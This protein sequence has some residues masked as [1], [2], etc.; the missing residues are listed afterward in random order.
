MREA[1]PLP[2]AEGVASVDRPEA[3]A[4]AKRRN[5]VASPGA[6][7]GAASSCLPLLPPLSSISNQLLRS[8]Y[9]RSGRSPARC[10]APR[11][12]PPPIATITASARAA[13][14]PPEE[15]SSI[16]CGGG[17]PNAPRSNPPP[18][19]SGAATGQSELGATTRT[20][21]RITTTGWTGLDAGFGI[22]AQD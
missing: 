12:P 17:H 2:E 3:V 11:P 9:W 7:G 1:A 13:E 10:A 15:S 20:A 5:T 14:Q 4:A 6:H 8:S 18:P 19:F 22:P 16:L 21:G